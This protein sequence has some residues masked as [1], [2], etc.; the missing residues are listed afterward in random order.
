MKQKS[1]VIFPYFWDETARNHESLSLVQLLSLVM[2]PAWG[3]M[4][5]RWNCTYVH[6][7]SS[8]LNLYRS[9]PQNLA[10]IYGIYGP[11]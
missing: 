10:K 5:V 6:I 11:T 7:L 4:I 2:N 3:F 8:F 9:E 1:S